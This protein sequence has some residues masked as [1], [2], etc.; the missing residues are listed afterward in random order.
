[1]DQTVLNYVFCKSFAKLPRRFNTPVTASRRPLK[2]ADMENRIIHLV[3]YPKPWDA[4]GILNGQYYLF[5]AWLQKTEWRSR[6]TTFFQWRT[7]R[8]AHAILK[9]FPN[10]FRNIRRHSRDIMRQIENYAD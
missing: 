7:L 9:C 3:A 8:K 10:L 6:P 1:M 5:Q 4:L 2:F